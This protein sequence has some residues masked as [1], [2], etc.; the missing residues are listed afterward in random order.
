[1]STLDLATVPVD[2]IGRSVFLTEPA[3]ATQVSETKAE[4]AMTMQDVAA[5]VEAAEALQAEIADY[6][7]AQSQ[8]R[9]DLEEYISN[10]F[11]Q[12]DEETDDALVHLPRNYDDVLAAMDA[13]AAERDRAQIVGDVQGGEDDV[14][15]A[16]IESDW[17]QMM[18]WGEGGLGRE[19]EGSLPDRIAKGMA[20]MKQLDARL[21]R[22]HQ[23][24]K[25]LQAQHR[26]D[27]AG[28]DDE[29]N[30]GEDREEEGGRSRSSLR[31]VRRPKTYADVPGASGVA[32]TREEEDLVARVMADEDDEYATAH[33]PTAEE[34]AS[35]KRINEALRGY[36]PEQ[37]WED[38]SLMSCFG[39]PDNVKT[40]GAQAIEEASTTATGKRDY[41]REA[42]IN[43]AYRD[44]L[45]SVEASLRK[46][47]TLEDE[48]AEP[49][50]IRSL[51]VDALIE[52]SAAGTVSIDDLRSLGSDLLSDQDWAAAASTDPSSYTP[53]RL[54]S[55]PTA[56]LS[57]LS[58]G[59][60]QHE[61]QHQPQHE[62]EP[63][64]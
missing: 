9:A 35:L 43:R 24:S 42:R 50:L 64:E 60:P 19:G 51:L 14:S 17:S 3:L 55:S 22:L 54:Q 40:S 49:D 1:M 16:S 30:E 34:V 15:V 57:L 8:K 31:R 23:E 39:D 36:A 37:V 18:D 44:K 58:Q 61:P 21:L 10:L 33:L 6:V 38:A 53:I 20:L 47:H 56:L 4:L 29:G 25:Q 41:L 45:F 28:G 12:K 2:E 7:V 13:A 48:N 63:Q 59:Q 32:M 52:Q 5:E 46:L 26:D 62:N 11:A 27:D